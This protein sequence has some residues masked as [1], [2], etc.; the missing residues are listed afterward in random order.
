M[1][2]G[3]LNMEETQLMSDVIDRPSR[4]VAAPA[5]ETMTPLALIERAVERGLDP[6][7]LKALV[8]LQE[9]WHANRA[10]EEFAAAMNACQQELPLIVKDANNSQTKSAYV[11]ME[12][13][14]HIAKPIISKHGFSLSF[15]EAD[16]PVPEMKRTICDVRHSAGHCEQY[17]LDLPL[18]G[19]GAK[20][21]AIGAMNRVQAAISTGS[22][23][24]R[25]LTCRIFN[26]T[27]S[28]TDIDGRLPQ[29]PNPE[30]DAEAP[31]APPRAKRNDPPPPAAPPTEPNKH[32]V[33]F[34]EVGRVSAK[35]KKD[36]A[37]QKEDRAAFSDWVWRIVGRDMSGGWGEWTKQDLNK[38]RSAL[39]LL[40]DEEIPF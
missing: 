16:S 13:V 2:Q 1:S 38:C 17:H 15:G 4:Q 34:E 28:G 21:N 26:I 20:G 36:N 23:A 11:R 27:I 32:G 37:S 35:W 40:T 18:D 8:M 22:Y 14:Q 5:R 9:H 24:Q 39:G 19:V 30:A 12:T 10:R 6:E 31:K 3:T 25:Y 33:R 29:Y 7:Q